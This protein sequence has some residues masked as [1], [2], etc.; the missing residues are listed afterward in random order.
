MTSAREIL[1]HG[2][3][4][5]AYCCARLLRNAGFR[6]ALDQPE[7]TRVPA[8][9]LS[10]PALALIRDVFGQPSLFAGLPRIERRV[11]RWGEAAEPVTVAH[12]A[13]VVAETSLLE[14]LSRGF[15]PDILVSP[16]FTIHTSKPLPPVVTEHRFGSRSAV[17]AEVALKDP[18]DLS[19]CWIE[20]LEAGW[21]FLIP[22]ASESTWLLAVGGSLESLLE[23]SRLIAP[24]IDVLHIGSAGF[25]ACPRIV[26]P[27]YG[28]G[29]L[30]CGTAAVGFDPICGDGVANAIREAILASAVIRGIADGG[31]APSL[32]AHYE[33]R[34]TSGMLRHLGLS[35][36][37][38]QTGGSGP[39]WRTELASLAEGQRWCAT[40]L[41]GA[42]EPRYQ[43]RD[44]V[45]E[46]RI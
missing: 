44:F 15:E 13:V 16:E 34:L 5:A 24:R 1:I 10:D 25:I 17:A 26:S 23:Q 39:W 41:S 43:L 46:C 21:F 45:L 32:L 33:S 4:V 8:I 20:S 11:V 12:S 31:D 38:Y 7:R 37:F 22:N 3:G 19:S 18:A 42:G 40:R 9:M 29:W 30:A 2:D 35:A 27:L 36:E 14:N 6:V 28:D